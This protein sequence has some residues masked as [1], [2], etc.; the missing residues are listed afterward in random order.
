MNTVLRYEKVMWTSLLRWIRLLPP[1]DQPGT[2]TFARGAAAASFIWAFIVVSAV[3]LVAVD[4]LL[5]RWT[6]ARVVADILGVYGLIWMVGLLAMVHMH[7]HAVTPDHL[8][9]RSGPFLEVRIPRDQIDDVRLRRRYYTAAGRVQIDG[10]T[11]SLVSNGQTQVELRLRTP[12]T[13]LDTDVTE[14]R[15]AVDD[16]NG[17]IRALQHTPTARIQ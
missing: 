5:R 16:P 7:P 17:F 8:V 3:E 10:R 15:I 12:V 9:L 2:V 11:A 6:A 13:I 4:L 1:A 14:I